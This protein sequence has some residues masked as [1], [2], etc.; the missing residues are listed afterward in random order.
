MLGMLVACGGTQA[1][2]TIQTPADFDTTVTQ[3][4]DQVIDVFHSDGLNCELVTRDLKDVGKS[5][6][7]Q[8][9]KDWAASHPEAK[10][11]AKKTIAARQKDLD[12]ASASALHQ[13]GP[14][15]IG[16]VLDKLSSI[17]KPE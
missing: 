17:S 15:D 4:I 3:L 5:W 9:A 2:T 14:Q 13:C 10:E 7:L 1:K 12:A 11:S 6:T 16:A 8:S